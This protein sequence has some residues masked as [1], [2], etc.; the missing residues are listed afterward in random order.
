MRIIINRYKDMN[1]VVSFPIIFPIISMAWQWR[2]GNSSY[3][4]I[5]DRG[6]NL[7]SDDLADS[8]WGWASLSDEDSERMQDFIENI[9]VMASQPTPPLTYP[10]PEIRPY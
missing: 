3:P 2:L 1:S 10:P 8:R 7:C 4:D 5:A 6:Q 9:D